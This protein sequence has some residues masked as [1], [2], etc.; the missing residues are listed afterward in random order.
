[1]S[2]INLSNHPSD[3]WSEA[4]RAAAGQYGQIIDMPF[5]TI[6]P[7]ITDDKMDALVQERFTQI[8][9][10]PEPTVMLQGESVFTYR[11]VH[12]LNQAGVT[13]LAAV[14]IRESKEVQI[15]DGT[16]VKQSVFRFAGFRKY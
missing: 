1:M 5:P 10:Q 7:D 6:P 9:Q 3:F 16:T 2:F 13:T 4:Q 11:L 15:E 8:L 12:R 14:S